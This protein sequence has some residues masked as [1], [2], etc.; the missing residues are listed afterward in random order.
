MMHGFEKQADKFVYLQ[1]QVSRIYVWNFI[2][3]SYM[4]L[5]SLLLRILQ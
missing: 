3:I 5:L 2:I 1:F 4:L